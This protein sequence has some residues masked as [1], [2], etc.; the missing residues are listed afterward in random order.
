LSCNCYALH[1]SPHWMFFLYHAR[2][3]VNK[4]GELWLMSSVTGASSV[5]TLRIM[6]LLPVWPS[7]RHKDKETWTCSDSIEE[8]I[9]S[10]RNCLKEFHSDSPESKECSS[11]M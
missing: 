8:K 7:Y 9:Q 6:T 3:N 11:I 2:W 10:M 4:H 1:I 5:P